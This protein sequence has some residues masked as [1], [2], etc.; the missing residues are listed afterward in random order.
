[1][2]RCSRSLQPSPPPSSPSSPLPSLA[3]PSYFPPDLNLHLPHSVPPHHHRPSTS[4]GSV[5]SGLGTSA[6]TCHPLH[7]RHFFSLSQ[8]N[9]Q[10]FTSVSCQGALP[11]RPPSSPFPPTTT[12]SFPFPSTNIYHDSKRLQF[13]FLKKARR[14]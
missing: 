13:I 2:S 4:F 6:A 8:T 9:L 3:H 1:M 14:A 7:H 12:S 11:T 10:L 5:K